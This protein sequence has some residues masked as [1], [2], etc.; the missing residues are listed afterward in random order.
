[1]AWPPHCTFCGVPVPSPFLGNSYLQTA[2]HLA[3]LMWHQHCGLC[4]L[5]V[6]R[7]R[8][9]LRGSPSDIRLFPHW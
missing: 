3:R 6:A 8:I 2:S 1:M 5:L 9:A 7:G 4:W